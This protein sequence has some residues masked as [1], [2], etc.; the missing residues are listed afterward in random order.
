MLCDDDT[1]FDQIAQLEME[2]TEILSYLAKI[3]L[4]VRTE[5]AGLKA[6]EERLHARRKAL[7]RKEDRLIAILDRECNGVKTD[8]GVATVAYRKTT[9]TEVTDN[10]MAVA[11]LQENG[12][13]D[14][15]KQEAP[16][17]SLSDVKRL[18][19]GGTKV[20]GVMLVQGLSCSV[21]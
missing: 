12:Y 9:K 5:A 14:C 17:V 11:W 20:P 8:V 10:D 18:L 15:W 6:E 19:T 1:L 7:E 21:K 16:K 2:R 4:N 13:D 3:V